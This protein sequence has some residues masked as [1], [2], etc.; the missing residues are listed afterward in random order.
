[1]IAA[2]ASAL[3]F[4][5]AHL[6]PLE[7]EHMATVIAEEAYFA[8][9]DPVT[10]AA[11]GWCE[12]G[13]RPRTLHAGTYGFTQTRRRMVTVRTQAAEGARALKYW[14]DWEG[15]CKHREPHHWSLH[16][17][18]G[19]TIPRR[20]LGIDNLKMWRVARLLERHM[21]ATMRKRPGM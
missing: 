11:R 14:Q 4:F 16:Y 13:M 17:S 3:L 9:I 1:V 8:N 12:S 10:L 19:Y 7:A 20:F 21:Y 5:F 6:H 15:R 2:L 18:H